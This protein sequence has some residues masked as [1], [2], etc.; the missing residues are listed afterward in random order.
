MTLKVFKHTKERK[1]RDKERDRKIKLV[2]KRQMKTVWNNLRN[3]EKQID[4]DR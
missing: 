4:D 3:W 2:W 1:E